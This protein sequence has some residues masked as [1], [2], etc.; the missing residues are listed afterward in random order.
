TAELLDTDCGTPAE[1]AASLND[2][3]RGNRW[4]GGISTNAAMIER[5]AR[6]AN[7]SSLSLLEVAAGSGY[8]PETARY[9]L[10]HRGLQL[11]IALL[12]RAPSHLHNGNRA[13][14]GDAL[15]LPF[16]DTS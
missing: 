12:D 11:Q 1:V 2:L 8:V 5:A 7:R 3:R 9:R 15:A 13:V 10:Q 14:A 16:Q 4:F 6:R